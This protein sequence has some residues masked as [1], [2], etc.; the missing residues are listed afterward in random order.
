MHQFQPNSDGDGAH[1]RP[2][3]QSK[4]VRPKSTAEVAQGRNHNTPGREREIKRNTLAKNWMKRKTNK[5]IFRVCSLVLRFWCGVCRYRIS[6][7][8]SLS[9]CLHVSELVCACI[10]QFHVRQHTINTKYTFC[11][12]G[13]WCECFCPS[14]VAP[15]SAVRWWFRQTCIIIH[16][17]NK[18]IHGVRKK[19]QL[20]VQ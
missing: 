13:W 8:R 10:Y 17:K 15:N 12:L 9:L 16:N 20:W 19:H 4:N 1:K 3:E 5:E 6:L 14:P 11:D 7:S 2:F 18:S